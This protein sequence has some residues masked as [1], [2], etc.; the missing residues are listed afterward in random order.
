M[1]FIS[2]SKSV[3]GMNKPYIAEESEKYVYVVELDTQGS[4][5]EKQTFVFQKNGLLA[6]IGSNN[7]VEKASKMLNLDDPRYK[8]I[9]QYIL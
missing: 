9:K 6:Y 5:I 2:I 8:G 3:F 7:F 1:D 4:E